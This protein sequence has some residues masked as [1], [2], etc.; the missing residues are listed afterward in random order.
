MTFKE[1]RA[2]KN[3]FFEKDQTGKYYTYPDYEEIE[4]DWLEAIPSHWDTVKLKYLGTFR[5]GKRPPAKDDNG[6]FP[7]IG[8]N[9]KVGY[10]DKQNLDEKRIVIGRV[11]SSGEVN[12]AP[13]NSWVTDNAIILNHKLYDGKFRYLFYVLKSLDLKSL[14]TKNAQPLITA[15]II[16]EQFIPLIPNREQEAIVKFLDRE[17]SKIDRL[18]EEEEK[19]LDLLKEKRRALISDILTKGIDEEVSLYRETD[20]EWLG[21]IPSHWETAKLKHLVHIK[22]GG[23]P[24]TS[25]QNFWDGN[26]PWVSPKDMQPFKISDTKDYITQE[27]VKE[28]STNVVPEKSILL[29]VRSGILRRKI[30]VSLTKIPVALNQDLK[31]LITKQEIHPSYL[32]N[33]IDSFSNHLLP[34]WK[35]EGTTVESLETENVINTSIPIPPYREQVKIVSLIETERNKIRNLEDKIKEGIKILKEY[36]TALISAAVTGKIDVRGEV[37]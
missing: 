2:S 37:E 32:A 5:S 26:I 20:I 30:P 21:S 18:I 29:V 6:H 15:N 24:S 33:F 28:S 25:N 9:G 17:T 1:D 13:Q 10:C 35:K 12:I 34:L 7:I 31:G 23:T 11:G 16:K 4:V 3:K 19:L 36:R 27:A 8:A 22:G 14:I